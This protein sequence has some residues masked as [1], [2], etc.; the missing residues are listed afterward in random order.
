[1]SASTGSTETKRTKN[2]R[3]LYW[4]G[5]SENTKLKI[6]LHAYNDLTHVL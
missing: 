4:N 5:P 3:A 1:V 2:M 6:E